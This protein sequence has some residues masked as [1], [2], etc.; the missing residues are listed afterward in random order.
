M[1]LTEFKVMTFDVVGTLIDFERGICDSVRQSAG[2]AGAALDDDAIL[3]AY[4]TARAAPGAGW[5]PD[6]L[7]RVYLQ[8]APALGLPADRE[9]A[10]WLR[11]SVERWPAFPDS[12][13]ALQRLGARFRL[14][15]MTNAQRWAARHFAGTLGDPFDGVV[16]VDDVGLE[17]PDPQFFAFARGV[18]S[19]W[20]YGMADI[21]HVAQS[22][23]HDIG[24]ARALGYKVCWIE[25]RKGMKGYG[26]T[27]E[28]AR[29]T[30]P[31]YHVSTLAE[32]ADA[33]DQAWTGA[34][35]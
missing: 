30:T 11:A 29:V 5:F 32:L 25:R 22:Q 9:A 34:V 6:D 27:R 19:T 33:V 16:T 15:A 3:D 20:G 13:E 4:R 18:I 24:V 26:G 31:D 10:G 1:S 2:V 17:K 14:V 12:A 35:A 8:M 28:P 23:Y 21:L 7:E